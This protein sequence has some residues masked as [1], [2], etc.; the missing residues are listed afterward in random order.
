[1]KKAK[2][3]I[4]LVSFLISAM[5]CVSAFPMAGA[6]DEDAVLPDEKES[7]VSTEKSDEADTQQAATEEKTVKETSEK[8]VYTQ[9]DKIMDFALSEVGYTQQNGYNKFSAEFGNGYTA[10]CN[11]FVV[12]CAKQAGVS[13][14]AI[15]GTSSYNG[16]CYIYMS[17]LRNQG[18]FFV[19]DGSYTPKK[20]DLVFYNSTK[21]TS[22][23]TH[24]GFVLEADADTVT[25][26]EGNVT[27]NGTRGVGRNVRPR[28]SYVGDMII[29]G[30]GVPAYSG[31][32][33]PEAVIKNNGYSSQQIEDEKEKE[34][35]DVDKFETNSSVETR[36]AL[37]DSIRNAV[38]PKEN[39]KHIEF[40]TVVKM[41]CRPNMYYTDSNT[42][43]ICYETK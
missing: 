9:R 11:Y 4:L 21:S 25:T 39:C 7:V 43:C 26:V 31:E 14:E 28:Y 24:I 13:P 38:D 16:N 32:A 22:G 30:F 17:A 15:T 37:T 34:L 40:A 29:I 33:V 23:S 1:L 12:W 20:G 35:I 27:V 42:V 5:S 18:R 8:P 10:W 19:N 2:I 36:I 41:S 3:K 6:V